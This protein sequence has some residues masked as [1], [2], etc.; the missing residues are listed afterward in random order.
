MTWT[1]PPRDVIAFR[2]ALINCITVSGTILVGLNL[3]QMQ[4]RFH[5]PRADFRTDTLPGFVLSR[6]RKHVDRMDAYGGSGKGTVMA[7]LFVPDATVDTGTTEQYADGIADD[8][9]S[10]SIADTLYVV[11][12]DVGECIDP[13]PAMYSG[14]VGGQPDEASVTFRVI[15]ISADWEG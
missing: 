8:L 6:P 15:S 14:A 3:A 2:D 9:A 12:V 4:A 5:Y 10:L 13:S 7:H 11:S 1:N